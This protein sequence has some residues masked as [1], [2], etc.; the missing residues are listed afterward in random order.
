[1]AVFRRGRLGGTAG[2]QSRAAGISLV[3]VCLG[4]GVVGVVTAV[5]LTS[6]DG[7]VASGSESADEVAIEV[8]LRDAQQRAVAEGRA[9]CVDVDRESRTYA[10]VKG[11]C[12]SESPEVLR[13]PF[14]LASGAGGDLRDQAVDDTGRITTR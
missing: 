11:A 14:P 8:L 13:G 12:D 7:L 10:L 6:F 5:A 3:E 2:W 1:M 4:V 9:M